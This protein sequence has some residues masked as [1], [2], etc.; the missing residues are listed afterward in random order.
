MMKN[1]FDYL[2]T[3]NRELNE[4]AFDSFANWMF[5]GDDPANELSRKLLRW[6]VL[7]IIHDSTKA[8]ENEDFYRF[9]QEFERTDF[10]SFLNHVL[11]YPDIAAAVEETMGGEDA[12][13]Y[14]GDN[15]S[16]YWYFF[17]T[18]MDH[19]K[20]KTLFPD[21]PKVKRSILPFERN[22]PTTDLPEKRQPTLPEDDEK[23][24]LIVFK[25]LF[26][27]LVAGLLLFNLF[28]K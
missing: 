24:L 13:I 27:F 10:D 9:F 20:Q 4:E 5:E 28:L 8:P 17:G 11:K 25:A 19:V 1:I 23:R 18:V 12:S 6:S 22:K 26:F 2:I 7:Y 16:T 14:S 21:Q 3:E 15:E